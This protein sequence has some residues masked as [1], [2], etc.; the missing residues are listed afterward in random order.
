[1]IGHLATQIPV[2]AF[3]SCKEQQLM[4]RLQINCQSSLLLAAYGQYKK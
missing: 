3:F 2:F 4:Q 1:M